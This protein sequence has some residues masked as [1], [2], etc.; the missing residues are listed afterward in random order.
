MRRIGNLY[1]KLYNFDN[2]LLAEKRARKG[3]LKQ[4][5]IIEF[6][7]NR[8]KYLKEIQNLLIREEYK[9]SQYSIFTIFDKK[10]R[11]IFVLP[12]RDRIVQHAIA[13]Q[14]FPILKKCLI[15]QTYSCIPKK[16][17]HECLQDTYKECRNYKY[18]LKIDIHKYYESINKS[19]LKVFL[20]KKFKDR[21]L[22]S[23][24]DGIIDSNLK[25]I[26]IGNYLSQIFAN[27]YLTYFDHWLKEAKKVSVFR[28]MDDI[29]ILHNSKEYLHELKNEIESYLYNIL[30]LRL[31]KWQIF[32]INS[33]GIDFVGY[34]IYPTYIKLRKQIKQNF[35]TMLHKYPNE[36]SISSYKGWL[37]HGNCVNLW[38]KYINNENIKFN[39]R[40]SSTILQ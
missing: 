38:N 14:I 27:F 32:P 16:G 4:K 3:K 29:V 5:G 19:T 2:L 28:Y 1:E 36:N 15:S 11:Q 9:T 22:L 33:R 6:S 10:E 40:T 12:Y 18:C 30:D 21:K 34:V 31:S 39:K 24:L 25:G 23:L 17:I 26:P 20:R 13:Q 8:I 37:I 7:K 35:K